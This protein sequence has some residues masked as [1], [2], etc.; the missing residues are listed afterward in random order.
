M[1]W[2]GLWAFGFGVEFMWFRGSE[3]ILQRLG[4]KFRAMT[5]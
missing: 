5:L 1:G 2:G 4:R 3:T